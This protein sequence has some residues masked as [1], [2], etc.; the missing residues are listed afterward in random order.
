M[1]L[2]RRSSAAVAIAALLSLT[3]CG[4]V[5]WRVER[6][7][8]ASRREAVQLGLMIVE[9]RTLGRQP[10]PGFEG[11]SA[12][13]LFKSAAFYQGRLCL[14]GPTGLFVYSTDG[15]LEHIYRV[16]IDLPAAP[17]GE[18]VVG[19]LTGSRRQELLIATMGEGVLAFDG[20]SFRQIRARQEE[21]RT[22]TA[23][24]PLGSGRLLIGTNKLGLLI[25]DGKTLKHFHSTTDNVYVTALAGAEAELWVGTLNDG[26]IHFRGGQSERIDEEQG[27]PDRRVEQ[28]AL[29]ADRAYV[30]TPLGV[31]EVREGKVAR[32][33]A[34]GRYARA[35]MVEG[36]ALLVG[37][38]QEGILRVPLNG[39][40]GD[41]QARRAIAAVGGV[42]LDDS[43]QFRRGRGMDGT[44]SDLSDPAKEKI[45]AA[46]ITI[47]G[48]LAMG[49]RRYAL[50]SDGVLEREPGGEWRRVLSGGGAQLTDRNISALMVALDGRLWV[51]YFDRGM[52]ILSANGDL[53]HIE[54]EQVFC[55]NRIVEEARSGAVVVATANGLVTFDRDGRQK[56]VL[57]REDGLIAEHVNDVALYHDGL[58]GEGMALATPAGITFMDASGAHSIY[59]FQGL[60]N[61]HVYALGASGDQLIA[62]TLGGLSL[63]TDGEVHRNLNTGNSGLKHNWITALAGVGGDWLVG[64]YGAGVLRLEA[65]GSVT[66]TEATQAGVVVNPTAMVADGRLVLAGTLGKGLMVGDATGTRWRTITAGL[67]SLNVTALAIHEGVVY[68]GTENGLVKISEGKL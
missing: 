30:G 17:L 61:N 58:S 36:D 64:T 16:G 18:M 55:V 65:D 6:A 3:V 56:Q 66:P 39:A 42:G 37:Q 23:I 1:K 47:E 11:I 31:A 48:F 14:A 20:E 62:G 22:V 4:I 9:E 60:I 35:L 57:T 25:Y 27:L 34:R 29:G 24:L 7:L 10:N 2:R 32:V 38:M 44:R 68:V 15:V 43:H 45:G 51:G 59:A 46:G 63:L 67:P 33:L 49:A 28:I 26:L 54:N 12:P 41:V 53:K 50:A 52:D 19:V 13:A 5:A 40:T 21:A 8:N